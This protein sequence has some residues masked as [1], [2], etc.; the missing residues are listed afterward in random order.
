MV[1]VSQATNTITVN[2]MPSGMSRYTQGYSYQR[3]TKTWKDWCPLCGSINCL[4]DNP[5]GTYEGEITCG[6]CGADYDGVTGQ[7]KNGGG[8]RGCLV[9]ADGTD[10]SSTSTESKTIT[11]GYDIEKPFQCFLRIEYSTSPELTSPRKKIQF[12]FTEDAPDIFPSFDGDNGITPAFLNMTS[13]SNRINV[14]DK[15]RIIEGDFEKK[16]HYY[17]RQIS[18]CH[19]AQ[20]TDEQKPWDDSEGT[21]DS[22][23]KM[24]LDTVAFT[25]LPV[26]NPEALEACGKTVLENINTLIEK[27]KY[28][29]TMEYGD[30]RF[31]DY[32]R[33][34]TETEDDG[35]TLLTYTKL[36]GETVTQKVGLFVRQDSNVISIDNITYDPINTLVNDSIKVFK[37]QSDPA[38]DTTIKYN[39]VQ[40]RNPESILRYGDCEDVESLSET[41]SPWEAYY[42]AYTNDKLIHRDKLANGCAYTYTVT[43][44]GV[45]AMMGIGKKAYC[46]FDNPMLNDI[47]T[48]ESI[49]VDYDV[50]KRPRIRTKLGLGEVENI[51]KG[52]LDMQQQRVEIKNRRSTYSDGAT[53]TTAEITKTGDT[54]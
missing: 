49:E 10:S 40:S 42:L 38:D 23:C 6:H 54:K 21:D 5:K 16:N 36:N 7:D 29:L 28:H 51:Q 47:K 48:V 31:N 17:L 22:S 30:F 43:I 39:Y 34:K 37:T 25:S 44:E 20:K 26:V 13:R 32:L 27:C 19:S 3:Y 35:D 14:V 33:F 8:S 50:S 1:D 11:H 12:S 4:Q 53:Y 24:I 46:T 45:P 41:T 2:Q 18:L 9:A 15:I 52:R